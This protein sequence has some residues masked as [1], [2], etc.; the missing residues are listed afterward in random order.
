MDTSLARLQSATE[1]AI[2]DNTEN[3]L[4]Q[5]AEMSTALSKMRRELD[6]NGEMQEQIAAS[7]I[8]AT[9]KISDDVQT[10][11]KDIKK[12]LSLQQEVKAVKSQDKIES[13]ELSG[14]VVRHFYGLVL[15]SKTK[16]FPDMLAVL[17][18][19]EKSQVEGTG[20]W[21]FEHPDW[22][23]WADFSETSPCLL[24]LEGRP[25]MGKTYLSLSIYQHLYELRNAEQ[26][27]CV[28]YFSCHRPDEQRRHATD[29]LRNCAIQI[30][31]QSPVI[32]QKLE[33]MWRKFQIHEGIRVDDIIWTEDNE[34][35]VF[36]NFRENSGNQLFVVID[37]IDEFH[38]EEIVRFNNLIRKV[39]REK[40]QIKF[41]VTSDAIDT[42]PS[43]CIRI[44][45]QQILP[46][47]RKIV[48][49][50]IN[51][52]DSAY[53]GLRKL[54]KHYK[55]KLARNIEHNANGKVSL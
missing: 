30:A 2:L 16:P 34:I 39:D 14:N 3:M 42:I 13:D 25:G 20:S 19:L 7:Q 55:Q 33:S 52:E 27:V 11:M 35:F 24:R 23:V 9:E 17:A 36:D 50:R 6:R 41:V 5:Q 15:K 38:Y 4:D 8:A 43:Q 29:L 21:L 10:M 31:D 32:R 18:N 49:E 44:A 26:E 53:E 54:S 48:W 40:L 46:D 22:I 28:A 37:G 47:L 51:S 12:L 1:L 45:K